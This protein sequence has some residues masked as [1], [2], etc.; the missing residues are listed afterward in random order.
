MIEDNGH[1]AMGKVQ[2][3]IK[4]GFDLVAAFAGIVVCSPVFLIISLLIT[5]QG[6]GPV[7]FR[8][9]RIGYKGRPFAI[10]K[11]RTMSS[12]VEEEGPQLVA[13]C[14]ETNSTRL[15]QFLRG[16]HLDELPQ[17]W[18]VLRGD[19][20]FVGPRPERKFF[21]DK[22]MEQTDRY[23]LIYLMRPGLTS[24]ATLYNGYTD[25]MEKMLRRMEMDIHYLEHRTLRLDLNIILKTILNIATG[26]K[27]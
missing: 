16:H 7:F 24:E 22:I 6:N 27:F 19:M 21:I 10:F 18:N 13:G 4:R 17:L 5:Y 8:Q 11:F 9:I 14:D 12:V 26:K 25:T 3:C 1:D 23:R 15:E 20:S 2:R